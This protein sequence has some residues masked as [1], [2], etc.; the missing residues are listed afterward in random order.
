MFTIEMTQLTT[1][2]P[3]RNSVHVDGV[4][5]LDERRHDHHPLVV[6]RSDRLMVSILLTSF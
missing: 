3:G 6:G 1:A 5:T 2:F 4:T